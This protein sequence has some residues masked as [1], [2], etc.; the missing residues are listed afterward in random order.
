[1]KEWVFPMVR[2]GLGTSENPLQLWFPRWVEL[3]AAV[4][5][6]QDPWGWTPNRWHSLLWL[7]RGHRCVALCSQGCRGGSCLFAKLMS[8]PTPALGR[9]LMML[10][11]PTLLK[12]TPLLSR[13]SV[14]L[15]VS[16]AQW[17]WLMKMLLSSEATTHDLG[18]SFGLYLQQSHYI[19][20]SV[21]MN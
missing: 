10:W 11:K 6:E 9:E 19:T 5:A 21:Y 7:D 18:Y 13:T 15:L 3:W 12:E 14:L 8:L 1:M 2:S 20:N 17:E 16:H 4:T